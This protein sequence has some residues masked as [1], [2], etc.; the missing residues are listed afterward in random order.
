ME[1][2]NF[3]TKEEI[4]N[5]I[6]EK[7]DQRLKFV[8]KRLIILENWALI[9]SE[10]FDSV[11]QFIFKITECQDYDMTW[12]SVV[13]ANWME[14]LRIHLQAEEWSYKFDK[15]TKDDLQHIEAKPID[16]KELEIDVQEYV[17][18]VD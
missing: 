16:E 10:M 13:S 17:D 2:S 3:L 5:L 15:W 9:I 8:E 11:A 14:S 4:E 7:L 18:G 1:H 12:A 6:D